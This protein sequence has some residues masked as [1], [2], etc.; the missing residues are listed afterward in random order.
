VHEEVGNKEFGWQNGYAAYTVSDSGLAQVT[1]YIENQREHHKHQDF[2]EEYTQYLELHHIPY[3]PR[4]VF[5]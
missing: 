3:D 4:Y 1:K 2:K 5:D